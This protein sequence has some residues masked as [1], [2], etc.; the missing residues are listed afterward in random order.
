MSDSGPVHKI[1]CSI[2][3]LQS[4]W[5]PTY[6]TC[7]CSCWVAFLRWLMM[8]MMTR[9][10]MIEDDLKHG[11][12]EDD[13]EEP[14]SRAS[15]CCHRTSPLIHLSAVGRLV[16]TS[17]GPLG[18]VAHSRTPCGWCPIVQSTSGTFLSSFLPPWEDVAI[19]ERYFVSFS[20]M[21]LSVELQCATKA[22]SLFA[23]SSFAISR[24]GRGDAPAA[25]LT[26]HF[27]AFF[28]LGWK[29]WGANFDPSGGRTQIQWLK[30]LDDFWKC[31]EGEFGRDLV[32]EWRPPRGM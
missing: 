28:S 2:Y 13:S 22:R 29:C 7:R 23:V 16:P 30:N 25:A 5:P 11:M 8:T 27:A 32:G 12:I 4:I 24:D 10:S 20:N 21:S 17:R 18:D 19:M 9:Y 6:C 3:W 14:V 1:N 15:I 26:V 31:F